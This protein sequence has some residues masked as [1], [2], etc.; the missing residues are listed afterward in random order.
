LL[1]ELIAFCD[2]DLDTSVLDGPSFDRD[3][4]RDLLHEVRGCLQPQD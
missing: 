2:L 4:W 3:D 1:R